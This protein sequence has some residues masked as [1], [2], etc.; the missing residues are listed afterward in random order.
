MIKK[1]NE[2]V[3]HSERNSLIEEERQQSRLYDR[4]LLSLAAGA[5][6]LSFLFVRSIESPTELKFLF[7]GWLGFG[8]SLLITMVSFLTSQESYRRQVDI[9]DAIQQSDNCQSISEQNFWSSLTNWLNWG[10]LI[11]LVAGI[12]LL[13]I[14]ALKNV[15]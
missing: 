4:G 15:A 6:G 8:I 12:A 2:D 11:G 14:F 10:S 3:Y 9:L 13:A 1:L 7:L 5:F